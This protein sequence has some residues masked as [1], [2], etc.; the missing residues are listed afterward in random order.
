MQENAKIPSWVFPRLK[1]RLNR[2]AQLE[3]YVEG[4]TTKQQTQQNDRPAAQVPYVS[5]FSALSKVTINS[6]PKMSKKRQSTDKIEGET[7]RSKNSIGKLWFLSQLLTGNFR[8][9]GASQGRSNK[10]VRRWRDRPTGNCIS[11]SS[12]FLLAKAKVT[13]ISLRLYFTLPKLLYIH[14]YIPC[15]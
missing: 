14:T 8:F 1:S 12:F 13:T 2:H 4:K 10:G 6:R 11:G 9:W 15:T 5:S 7:K 3:R